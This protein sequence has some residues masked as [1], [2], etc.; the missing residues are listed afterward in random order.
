MAAA[1]RAHRLRQ[2]VLSEL[3]A[4]VQVML[5]CSNRQRPG[6]MLIRQLCG[7]FLTPLLCY[8]A[9][10]VSRCAGYASLDR[11][12][13]AVP[14]GTCQHSVGHS[15]RRRTRR[16]GAG[17]QQHQPGRSIHQVGGGLCFWAPRR[18]PGSSSASSGPFEQQL[19]TGA[20]CLQPTFL[21]GH[22]G[23]YP[24]TALSSCRTITT[25]ECSLLGPATAT[26]PNQA[27]AA[28]VSRTHSQDHALRHV[29]QHMAPTGSPQPAAVGQQLLHPVPAP[30]GRHLGHTVAA[31]CRHHSGRVGGGAGGAAGGTRAAPPPCLCA[32]VWRTQQPPLGGSP[33]AGAVWLTGAASARSGCGRGP[34]AAT[35]GPH[36]AVYEIVAAC[37]CDSCCCPTCCGHC[38]TLAVL[39]GV[40]V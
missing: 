14:H 22:T 30:E 17:R 19:P 5:A 1:A 15:C 40:G 7:I 20:G 26:P 23:P 4:R 2:A 37:V 16:P 35:A 29:G 39:G 9:G 13:H 34:A 25:N 3:Q 18:C 36:A 24:Y 27:W 38:P 32:W 8:A 21:A 33:R 31:P 28:Q 11:R 6:C 12:L 10:S